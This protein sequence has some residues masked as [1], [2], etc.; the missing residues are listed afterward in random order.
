MPR[1]ERGASLIEVLVAMAVIT[2]AAISALSF[3]IYGMGGIARQGN[4]L[5]AL[6]RARERLE[7]LMA[8]DINEVL[9]SDEDPH[10][11]SCSGS[12]CDWQL[13]KD[14]VSEQV[15]VN[16]LTGQIMRTTAELKDDP[17]ARTDTFDLVEFGVRVW[18]TP[19]LVDDDYHRVYLR[20]L[21]GR[22]S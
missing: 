5:A 8:A 4:R 9:P 3:F 14:P 13:S 6:E 20:T 10:W 1:G 12:P 22:F 17:T 15:T 18:F 7:Q 19:D 16:D 2:V 21:R 11:V